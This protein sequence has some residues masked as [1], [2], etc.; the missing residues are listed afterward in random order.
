MSNS[1]NLLLTLELNPH[2]HNNG[3]IFNSSYFAINLSYLIL[4]SVIEYKYSFL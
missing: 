1:Y 4:R 3:D 2:C